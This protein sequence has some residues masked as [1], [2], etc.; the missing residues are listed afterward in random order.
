MVKFL[1]VRA[2]TDVGFAASA[3]MLGF[4][5]T[6]GL[7]GIWGDALGMV[8]AMLAGLPWSFAVGLAPVHDLV[9]GVI[10][11]LVSIAIDAALLFARA[12]AA[13]RH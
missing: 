2:W 7:F 8:F 1:T 6:F 11:I 10:V 9:F 12:R 3:V 5:A 13:R 4:A